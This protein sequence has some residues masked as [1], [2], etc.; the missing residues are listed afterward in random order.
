MFGQRIRVP[1]HAVAA[2]H[3]AAA[4]V[5]KRFASVRANGEVDRCHQD[6]GPPLVGAA[7]RARLRAGSP[8]SAPT[9]SARRRRK[10]RPPPTAPCFDHLQRAREVG[11]A[12]NA[13]QQ[14]L[15]LREAPRHLVRLFGADPKIVVGQRRVVDAGHDRRLHVLEPLEAVQRR[16]G[17]HRGEHDRLVELAQAAA[18]ADERAARAEPGDEV[19]QPAARPAR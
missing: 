19:R 5:R 16:V 13:D 10:T 8:R 18:D 12:R 1:H 3:G 15:F 17:L 11:A 7:D 2:E 14:A 9:G 6:A 4:L